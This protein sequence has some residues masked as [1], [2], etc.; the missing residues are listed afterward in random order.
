MPAIKT[1]IRRMISFFSIRRCFQPIVSL[2][3]LTIRHAVNPCQSR[4]P[5]RSAGHVVGK[6]VQAGRRSCP[7][8]SPPAP[9]GCGINR[10]K[11]S[12]SCLCSHEGLHPAYLTL[13]CCRARLCSVAARHLP[14]QVFWLPR[15]FSYL[16]IAIH[17][18]SGVPRLKRF[19]FH[20][21]QKEAGSQRR[22]HFR[23]TRNSLL[24]LRT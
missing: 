6:G 3:A 18:N 5:A 15:L 17:R 7:N 9:L 19:P 22:D 1:T 8:A 16:P 11:K 2:R 13:L 21:T 12:P 23:I 14:R 10:Y 20:L 4:S 24:S